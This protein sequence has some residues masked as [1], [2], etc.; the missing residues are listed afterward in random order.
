MATYQ[1][2]PDHDNNNLSIIVTRKNKKSPGFVLK[3]SRTQVSTG[4][5]CSLSWNWEQL[6][7]IIS[8]RFLV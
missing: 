7:V 2:S 4:L 3:L 6:C 1:T 5:T 8:T